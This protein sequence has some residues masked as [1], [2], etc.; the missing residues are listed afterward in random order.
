M[1]PRFM[2]LFF[3]IVRDGRQYRSQPTAG[4]SAFCH[5]YH[6]VIVDPPL[7]DKAHYC[8]QDQCLGGDFRTGRFQRLAP[9]NDIAHHQRIN[10]MRHD[11]GLRGNRGTDTVIQ[12]R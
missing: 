7:P 6:L 2:G 4:G 1:S 5:C 11:K 9:H 3:D 12:N 10:D 8:H